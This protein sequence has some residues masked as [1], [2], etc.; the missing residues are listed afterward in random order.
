MQITLTIPDDIASD[1][2]NGSGTTLARRVLELA[3]IKAY[4]ANF[5]DEWGVIEML[6]FAGREELYEFFKQHEVRATHLNLQ[7]EHEKLAAL[8]ARSQ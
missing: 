3:A 1:I 7:Q 5:I 2:Q 4:E 8:L 6:K